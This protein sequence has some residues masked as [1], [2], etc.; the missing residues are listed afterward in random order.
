MV[1]LLKHI[2]K[3]QLFPIKIHRGIEA[4]IFDGILTVENRMAEIMVVVECLFN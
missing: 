1:H 2:L 4:V 3:Q